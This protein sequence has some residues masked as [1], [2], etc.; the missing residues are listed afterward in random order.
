MHTSTVTV[1]CMPEPTEA[2][3]HIDMRD[4]H[5]QATRGTGPGGQARNTTDSCIQVTHL[6]TKLTVRCDSERTALALLRS[7]LHTLAQTEQDEKNR[8]DRRA[9][10]GCGARGD[11]IRTIR[12]QDGQVNDHVTGRTWRLRD[13]LKGEWGD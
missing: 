2:E 7:R 4:L 1:A 10:V 5:I 12:Y 13:Y 11:K 6:P 9:Q 3:V 8:K